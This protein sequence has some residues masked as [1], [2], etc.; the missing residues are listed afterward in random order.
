MSKVS[1]SIALFTFCAALSTPLVASAPQFTT[2]DFPGAISTNITGGPNPRGESVGIYFDSTGFQHGFI[3]EKGEF[4]SFD[5][6]GSVSTTPGGI[7]PQGI[8]VGGFVDG[9]N[10]S[11]GFI[12][13][14]GKYET[15]NFPGAPGTVLTSLTASGEM[16]GFICDVPS[17][18]TQGTHSFVVSKKG[19]FTSFDPPGAVASGA[20]TVNAAGVVVGAY[21]DESGNEH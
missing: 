2:V 16:T 18:F 9:N 14:D 1:R 12:L 19:K 20:S 8:I 10:V 21:T 6:P 17:C 15:V 5:P 7:S 13:D 3:F 4:T 11:H